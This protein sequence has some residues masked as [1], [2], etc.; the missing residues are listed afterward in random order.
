M[1]LEEGEATF[2]P[3]LLIGQLQQK[4][5][6]FFDGLEFYESFDFGSIANPSHNSITDG[7]I[8][9]L[10]DL[11]AESKGLEAVVIEVAPFDGSNEMV[12]G[13]APGQDDFVVPDVE[14][15]DGIL[16]DDVILTD[17]IDSR[18]RMISL[19]LTS[20]ERMMASA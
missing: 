7:Q 2:T 3:E 14:E 17:D 13:E 12:D 9:A 6:S 11:Y 16:P 15:Q 20:K 8:G 1:E 5:A 4:L 10:I 18:V 19:F